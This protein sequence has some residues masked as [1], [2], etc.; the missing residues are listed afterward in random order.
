MDILIAMA[1]IDSTKPQD[2]ERTILDAIISYLSFLV[3][4]KK[5]IIIG[6]ITAATGAVLFSIISIVL[7]PQYSPLPNYY[8]SSAVLIIGQDNGGDMSLM[9]ASLGFVSP[10]SSGDIN[11]G[12]LAIRVLN[13]RPFIDEIVKKHDIVDYYGITSRLLTNSRKAI[14]NR[15]E[16][17]YES[18]TGTLTIHF[19]DIDPVFARDVTNSMVSVLRT[20]FSEWE[21]ANSQQELNAMEI[22]I[23]EVAQEMSR[24]EEEIKTFQEDYGVFSV[25]QLAES[26]A[27]LIAN[28]QT[29]LI[30]TEV[31]IE[32]YSRLSSIESQELYLLQAQRDSLRSLI[33]QI[34]QGEGGAGFQNMPS[35]DELPAL[36]I[37]YSHLRLSHDIQMRIYQNLQE[38]YEIKRLAS[39][40]TS[41]FSI[42]ESA[43]IEELKAR[44][45]R[46]KICIIATIV[47]FIL[48]IASAVV[49]SFIKSILNDPER[50]GSILGHKE[51]ELS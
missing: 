32:N 20:W 11:Y 38:Q 13:S 43:E 25:E 3:S 40:D 45:S 17:E 21:G 4:Y 12:E 5:L 31:A 47:G 14:L 6:T 33:R 39:V 10:G 19:E 7:P 16:F 15:S 51:K 49:Y 9:L 48:S 22:K 26:Q 34:E 18:R 42:L 27:T 46:S 44:P 23:K 29:E 35:K 1:D 8:Q 24:L 2:E 41:T 36:A 50:K 30:Q 28:L 37:E